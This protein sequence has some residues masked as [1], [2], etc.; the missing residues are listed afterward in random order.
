MAENRPVSK[1]LANCCCCCCCPPTPLPTTEPRAPP[2]QTRNTNM[3][4]LA[5]AALV[6]WAC[7]VG[8]AEGAGGA[9]S[10]KPTTSLQPDDTC[11]VPRVAPA[12]ATHE[13]SRSPPPTELDTAAFVSEISTTLQPFEYELTSDARNHKTLAHLGERVPETSEAVMTSTAFSGIWSKLSQV[14]QHDAAG[15]TAHQTTLAEAGRDEKPQVDMRSDGDEDDDGAYARDLTSYVAFDASTTTVEGAALSCAADAHHTRTAVLTC[16]GS[17]TGCVLRGQCGSSP[18]CPA[19]L[20]S[21]CQMAT[22]SPFSSTFTSTPTGYV[23]T[24]ASATTVEG[25]GLSFA[26][27]AHHT[28]TAVLTCDGSPTGCVLT[29]VGCKHTTLPSPT[30]CAIDRCR[31]RAIVLCLCLLVWL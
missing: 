20:D 13:P 28:G 12:A 14:M 5:R 17:A 16:D 8:R 1:E 31:F 2:T 19:G 23:A 18:G 21:C 30:H 11:A 24:D 26:A 7:L 9:T 22:C 27:D 29:C 4:N 6:V 3:P 15:T 25:A 10:V